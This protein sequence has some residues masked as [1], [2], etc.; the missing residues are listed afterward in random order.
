MTPCGKLY[1]STLKARSWLETGWRIQ[2]AFNMYIL[3]TNETK[4]LCGVLA[5]LNIN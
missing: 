2:S 4:V 5:V 3:L 1:H